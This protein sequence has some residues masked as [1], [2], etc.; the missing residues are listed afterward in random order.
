M[1]LSDIA[2]LLNE[3][4]QTVYSWHTSGK[5]PLP[6]APH[7]KSGLWLRDSIERWDAERTAHP[8]IST[9]RR[10]ASENRNSSLTDDVFG[11][12]F[13]HMETTTYYTATKFGEL[14]GITG[15]SVASG[16]KKGYYK[17]QAQT[18]TGTPLFSVEYVDRIVSE[19]KRKL[20]K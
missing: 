2:R 15:K 17:K 18:T 10:V 12:N 8:S 19:R 13:G 3:P 4:V 5:M 14:L 9:S 1:S 6:D 16:V 11:V 7:G 20:G